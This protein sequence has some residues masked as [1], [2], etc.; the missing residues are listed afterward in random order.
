[1]VEETS[2]R[3]TEEEAGVRGL[4][5]LSSEDITNIVELV[6]VV[7]SGTVLVEKEIILELPGLAADSV[8]TRK[9]ERVDTELAATEERV[10]V[11]IGSVLLLEGI[12]DGYVVLLK[13]PF[14][15][16]LVGSLD[17]VVLP[18]TNAD[19]RLPIW[20]E[21]LVTCEIS[22]AD[23]LTLERKLVT[24]E[25]RRGI[26]IGVRRLFSDCWVDRSS[27]I[28]IVAVSVL[29]NKC[30]IVIR[31]TIFLANGAIMPI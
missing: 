12:I 31:I 30:R 2:C 25:F 28:P 23:V 5:G 18:R 10:D 4:I 20:L 17:V 11:D 7:V 19:D 15:K 8:V 6:S 22:V 13:I 27:V 3:I 24:E 26:R 9:V 1:M 29:N 21:L 14:D 16:E